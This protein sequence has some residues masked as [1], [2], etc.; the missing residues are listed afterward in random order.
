MYVQGSRVEVC[1]PTRAVERERGVM[2]RG[3]DDRRNGTTEWSGSE[4][5]GKL[6]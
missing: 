4:C 1:K 5:G 3:L 2:L 6:D